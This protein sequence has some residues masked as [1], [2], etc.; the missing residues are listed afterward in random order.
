MTCVCFIRN[1]QKL[2]SEKEK[3]NSK[4]AKDINRHF[5]EEGIQMANGHMKRCLTSLGKC[6]LKLQWAYLSEWLK[7]KISD[8]IKCWWEYRETGLFVHCWWECKIVQPLWNVFQ[9][10]ILFNGSLKKAKH[11]LTRQPSNHTPG[12]LSQRNENA[13]ACRNVYTI[14]HSSFVCNSPK[15]ETTQISIT[16]E[17]LNKLWNIHTKE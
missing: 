11:T 7:L 8:S 10:A 6:K 17:G 2:N 14:V 15:L 12:H 9:S 16:S 4:C 5:I 3:S 1:S 13:H